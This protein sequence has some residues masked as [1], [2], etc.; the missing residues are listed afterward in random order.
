MATKL[1]RQGG[2]LAVLGVAQ[3]DMRWWHICRPGISLPIIEA[4]GNDGLRIGKSICN[5]VV[6]TNGYSADF[7]P[8]EGILCPACEE[9]Q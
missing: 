5:R 1:L 3:D 6:Y 7:R 9:R 8:P 4:A 2:R